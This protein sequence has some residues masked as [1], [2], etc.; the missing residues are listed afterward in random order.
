MQPLTAQ[1][2][3]YNLPVANSLRGNPPIPLKI[4]ILLMGGEG[5]AMLPSAAIV[6]K[7]RPHPF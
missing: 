4:S 1:D 3:T 5:G 6:G 2:F 7:G